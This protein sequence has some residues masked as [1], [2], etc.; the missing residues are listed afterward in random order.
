MLAWCS[1]GVRLASESKRSAIDKKTGYFSGIPGTNPGIPEKY[2]VFCKNI[3][4]ALQKAAVGAPNQ[5]LAKLVLT[6][7]SEQ[8]LAWANTQPSLVLATVF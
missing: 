3:A 1:P 8:V 2:P 5:V 7:G 6:P 4:F